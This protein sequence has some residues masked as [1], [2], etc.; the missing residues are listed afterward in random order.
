[1]QYGSLRDVLTKKGRNLS[2]K[3]KTKLLVD[4]AAGMC[5]SLLPC[6]IAVLTPI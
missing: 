3:L 4:A 2:W 6:H 1:M 5:V